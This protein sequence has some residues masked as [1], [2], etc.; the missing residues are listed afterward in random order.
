M[1]ILIHPVLA[2]MER[3]QLRFARSR[4]GSVLILV[5]CFILFMVWAQMVQR[6]YPPKPVP[7][8]NAVGQ[9]TGLLES[10]NSAGAVPS[11]TNAGI[12]PKPAG[13]E[14]LMVLTNDGARYTFTSHGGG[15]KTVE[16]L[17]YP[18][19]VSCGI[20]QT[21][22]PSNRVATLNPQALLPVLALTGGEALSGDG[23]FQLSRISGPVAGS[24]RS[25]PPV[26]SS[27]VSHRGRARLSS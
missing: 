6:L 21:V 23:M 25:N 19:L 5:V 2:V 24:R 26:E 14:V 8:T 9:S 7:R 16:L 12:A 22:S 11:A 10:A 15:L 3:I 1:R 17:K 18:E 4:P 27:A 20:R 13:P